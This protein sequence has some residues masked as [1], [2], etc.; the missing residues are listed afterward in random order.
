[1]TTNL[2]HI[3][4]GFGWFLGNFDN[5]QKHKHYAIQLAVPLTNPIKIAFNQVEL[6]TE[7]PVLI[8]SNVEHTLSSKHDHLL[9]LFNPIASTGHFWNNLIQDSFAE[10]DL[11]PTKKFKQLAL[12]RLKA[13]VTAT[14]FQK[15]LNEEIKVYDCFCKDFT[16]ATD[17]RIDAVINYLNQH[18]QQVISLEEISN[19]CNL[20]PSRFLHLFKEKTG[21]TYRR[22]QLWIRL[23]HA[24]PL[25]GEHNFTQIAHQAGFSDSAH[26]SRTFKENFGFSPRD[27]LKISQFIQ[28]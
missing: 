11:H 8:K 3:E 21:L 27:L 5:N 25:L 24:L 26:F 9:I 10:I 12:N 23:M 7:Q 20:S 2:V 6:L 17:P 22:A 16:H 19:F 18:F 14:A 13:K 15:L 1:M 28:V 4:K